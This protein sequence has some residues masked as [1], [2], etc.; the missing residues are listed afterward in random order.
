MTN[1]IDT[2]KSGKQWY[3][4]VSDNAFAFTDSVALI[5][6]ALESWVMPTV[7][8]MRSKEDAARY[9]FTAYVGRFYSRNYMYGCV[10]KLPINLPPNVPFLDMEYEERER[11]RDQ[12]PPF[13]GLSI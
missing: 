4:V 12:I 8:S 5:S 3:A 10:P 2:V 11:G 1:Q 13:P 9:A 7:T 6:M